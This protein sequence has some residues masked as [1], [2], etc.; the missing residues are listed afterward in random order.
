MTTAKPVPK[1]DNCAKCGV[2][3]CECGAKI[4]P[5]VDLPALEQLL[6]EAPAVSHVEIL[7]FPCTRPGLESIEAAISR[8]GLNRVVIA[9]CERRVMLKKAAG[10]G[11]DHHR[12]S[13]QH[14]SRQDGQPN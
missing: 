2:F 4:A 8:D 13:A 1:N 9:G 7:P 12:Q 14:D 10:N 5:R 11:C 6:R 3:L